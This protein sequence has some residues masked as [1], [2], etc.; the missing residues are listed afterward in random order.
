[1]AYLNDIPKF[2]FGTAYDVE[3]GE[4]TASYFKTLICTAVEFGCR[5]F[6]CAPLYKTQRLVGEVLCEKISHLG[7]SAFFITSKTPPNMMHEDKI[8]RSLR[9]TLYDLRVEYLDLFLIHAPFATKYISDDCSYPLDQEGNLLMDEDDGLL[10]RAWLK[11]VELKRRGIV[12]YIGISNV[13]IEQINR[14]HALYPIDVVQNEHHLLN[15]DTETIDHCEELDIHFEGY[16]GFGSPAKAK[17]E[18]KD[19][20]LAEKKVKTFA[21]M[22]NLTAGQVIIK[23]LH[24]QPL[25]YVVRSDN[26]SQL[27]DNIKATRQ[28]SL[29]LNDLIDLDRLNRNQRIFTYDHHNGLVRHREYPFRGEQPRPKKALSAHRDWSQNSDTS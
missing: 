13:N 18:G 23:W 20:F 9:K 25:S 1:M 29:S 21:Q 8:E 10:E 22:Y 24:Q 16:A 5:H 4:V 6:D 14:L 19:S 17:R 28:G 3:G 7:R 27:E 15:Q 12:R 2:A 11:M 26:R